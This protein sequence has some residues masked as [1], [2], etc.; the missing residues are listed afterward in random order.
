[1][2]ATLTDAAG[3]S[4]LVLIHGP[5]KA[6]DAYAQGNIGESLMFS[7][8]QA[9][10]VRPLIR[11]TYPLVTPRGNHA[12]SLPFAAVRQ[13]STLELAAL[14]AAVHT[15][16]VLALVRLRLNWGG[17][18]TVVLWGAMESVEPS[19]RGVAVT[20]KYVWSYGKAEIDVAEEE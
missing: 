11:A 19:C 18:S 6:T 7:A 12:G 8:R 5:A 14:W 17:L 4:S 10:S 13:F 20:I 9:V 16:A 2:T 3:G 1:M 15:T